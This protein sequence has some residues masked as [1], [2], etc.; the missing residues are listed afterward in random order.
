CD[1]AFSH[2]EDF[3]T[4]ART[5]RRAGHA[6]VLHGRRQGVP[7]LSVSTDHSRPRV[8]SVELFPVVSPVRWLL[9]SSQ[10]AKTSEK[11]SPMTLL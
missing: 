6:E 8:L 1:K 5:S 11:S 3:C 10:Q 4:P 9:L 7:A 2:C